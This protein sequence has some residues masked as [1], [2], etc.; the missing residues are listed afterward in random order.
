MSH[1]DVPAGVVGDPGRIGQII[2]NL[3]G[4]A[5]KFTEHGHVL[6]QVRCEE[7]RAG[8]TSACASPSSTPASASR[9]TST[10]TIFEAFSQAD[11]STTRRFGGTGLGLTISATLVKLMGGPHLGRQRARRRAARSSSR[12]T[13]PIVD[14]PA[15]SS[16]RM[17][18]ELPVLIVDDNDVNR[19]I[20]HDLLTRW[21]MKADRRGQRRR[22]AGGAA[23]PP[24]AEG[25]AVRTRPARRQHAGH[26]RLRCR[27]RRWRPGPSW[28]APP[29]M[30]LTS[31]GQFGDSD[32]LPRARYRTPISPSRSGR[33]ICTTP[34]TRRSGEAGRGARGRRRIDARREPVERARIL[35]AEDNIV[36]QRVAVGLLT[37]RGHTVDV[38]ANGLEA[39]AATTRSLRCRA[40]G[41]A[42]AR[43]GRDRGDRRYSRA[44]GVDRTHLRIVAMTAHAMTGDRERYLAAGM[45]GYLSKPIDSQ[46]LFAAVELHKP[47]AGSDSGRRGAGRLPR[48]STSKTCDDGSAATS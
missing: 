20:F 15:R 30:M 19:R 2:T 1:A 24:Q 31:S 48:R 40:D 32:P 5:I 12:V 36:N 34:S 43:D 8:R 46:A 35:L 16:T 6:V 26:G 14:P 10:P 29:I 28:A 39:L 17:L 41:R 38:V 42:D 33:P 4:N 7:R 25:T 9:R 13:L 37:S 44:R 47:T 23:P 3:V 27:R 18:T 11:G 45:D 22:R 21:Q